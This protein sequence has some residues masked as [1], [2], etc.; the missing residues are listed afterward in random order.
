MRISILKHNNREKYF[1]QARREGGAA[2]TVPRR[3]G[4]RGAPR[5]K[6]GGQGKEEVQGK[7][8]VQGKESIVQFYYDPKFQDSRM[9]AH[10][11][12]LRHLC[13]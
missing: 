13:L 9:S 8:G 6:R 10:S 7:E 1:A 3:P 12:Y 5:T 4:Q 2:G 11:P